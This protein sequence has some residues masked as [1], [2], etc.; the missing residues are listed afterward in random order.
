[1]FL[2]L[3]IKLKV[4][5]IMKPENSPFSLPWCL[6]VTKSGLK[7]TKRTILNGSLSDVKN[8]VHVVWEGL[9]VANLSQANVIASMKSV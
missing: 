3:Q 1:M 6:V 4:A 7:Q 8:P 2:I 9:Y 5:W